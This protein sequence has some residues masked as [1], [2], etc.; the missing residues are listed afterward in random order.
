M[1]RSECSRM[2]QWIH[3]QARVVEGDGEPDGRLLRH[4]DRV[5]P[6]EV[7]LIQ[8]L[9]EGAV[10]VE[11]V[12]HLRVV[13]DLPDLEAS[14]DDERLDVG[15]GPVV[16]E[17]ARLVVGALG[18]LLGQQ[19]LAA[20]GVGRDRQR[21]PMVPQRSGNAGAGF[22]GGAARAKVAIVRAP[23]SGRSWPRS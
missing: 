15:P 7:R 2:W 9:E 20:R 3:P 22:S 14:R 8:H 17:E 11:G 12:V 18:L 23:R 5:L 4:V 10:Q 6:A 1:P 16:D 21:H 19:E 13:R